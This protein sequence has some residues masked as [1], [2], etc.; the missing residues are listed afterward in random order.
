MIFYEIE[1]AQSAKKATLRG[2]SGLL[3][4]KVVTS[5][6]FHRPKTLKLTRAPKY[7][8]KSIP[9]V[10][11]LDQYTILRAPLV[12]ES[13]VRKIENDNTLVFLCDVRANKHQ[14]KKA[15]KTLYEVDC[16][17]INTLIR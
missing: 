16:I 6:Q 3:K 4:K 10:N 13:A 11:P 12:T 9:S 14:I 17:K 5:T 15:L 8:R 1:T 2:T 7:V